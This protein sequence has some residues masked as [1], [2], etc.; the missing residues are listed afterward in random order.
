[1]EYL[2]PSSRR[3]SMNEKRCTPVDCDIAVVRWTVP[4]ENCVEE[5]LLHST[6]RAFFNVQFLEMNADERLRKGESRKR[7]SI[8]F[9]L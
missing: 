8:I 2:S 7:V 1:M 5:I 3:C 9:L 4:M 6:A